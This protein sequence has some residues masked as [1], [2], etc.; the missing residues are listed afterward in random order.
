MVPQTGS[1]IDTP[2]E[3]GHFDAKV[4]HIL[5]LPESLFVRKLSLSVIF[6]HKICHT[7]GIFLLNID[8]LLYISTGVTINNLST[9]Y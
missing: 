3:G 1:T 8:Y 9:W 4:V 6:F 5:G 7:K 2:G